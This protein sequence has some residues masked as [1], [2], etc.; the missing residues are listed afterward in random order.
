MKRVVEACELCQLHMRSQARDSHRPALEQ[1][2]QPMLVIGI[3]RH[4]NKYL[5]LMDHFSGMAMY[6]KIGYSKDMEHTV[7]QLKRWFAN[8]G[9][10]RSI[11]CDNG[12][13]F[14]SR[15]FKEICNKYCIRLDFTSLYNP[16]SSRV[17]ERGVGL[18]KQIMKKT[19]EEGS[20]FKEALA[21]FRNTRN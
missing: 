11:R 10:S 8:F 7:R 20:C 21:A 19:E 13:P 12:P 9:V 3:E 18:I 6:E 16:S 14:F 17:T 15:R 2:S 4:G 5:L 1:V